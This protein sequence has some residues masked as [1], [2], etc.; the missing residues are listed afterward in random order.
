MQFCLIFLQ[1]YHFYKNQ[2]QKIIILGIQI[3]S[4]TN[5][6][7]SQLIF[8]L[9]YYS[10]MRNAILKGERLLLYKKLGNN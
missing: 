2:K 8:L 1:Y 7:S 3:C 4:K 10:F 9:K 5:V 6:F